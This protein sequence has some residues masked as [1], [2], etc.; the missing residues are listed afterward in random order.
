MGASPQSQSS[1]MEQNTSAMVFA[2]QSNNH[3]GHHRQ[4]DDANHIRLPC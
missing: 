4:E 1:H 2:A 3:S